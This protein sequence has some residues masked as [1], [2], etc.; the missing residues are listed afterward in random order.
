MATDCA[1]CSGVDD[2]RELNLGYDIIVLWF[3]VSTRSIQYHVIPR[4]FATNRRR[5]TA[6]FVFSEAKE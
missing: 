4:T 3:Q 2:T 1:D 5:P 6:N